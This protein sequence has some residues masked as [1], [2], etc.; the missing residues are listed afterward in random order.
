MTTPK[1]PAVRL[2]GVNGG[3]C[4][5]RDG[6]VLELP[7]SSKFS[8]SWPS[9]TR[10]A[11]TPPASERSNLSFSEGESE[12]SD[13]DS[14]N[15]HRNSPEHSNDA[16]VAATPMSART[17]AGPRSSP[18]LPRFSRALSMPLPSQLGYL[19]HPHRSGPQ[20][21]SLS[22]PATPDSEPLK[23]LSVEL[24][25]SVQMVIQTMLQ[26][27]PPQLLDP[28]KEQFSACALSVPI[29]SMSAILTS[30]K[31]LN[32]ISAN[33]PGLCSYPQ[34]PEG[35]RSTETSRACTPA[36]LIDFDIGEMLQSVGD[37]LSGAAAQAGVDLVLYHGDDIGL[38][39]VCVRGDEGGISYA[40]SHVRRKSTL[41][42]R[43][44]PDIFC[45]W[46]VRCWQ[47]LSRVTR[48][49]WDCSWD[50]WIRTLAL[51]Y[52]HQMTT[53]HQQNQRESRSLARYA[54][55]TNSEQQQPSAI[56]PLQLDLSPL[57]ILFSYSSFSVK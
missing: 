51:R 36:I 39:H 54:Y 16:K 11:S 30:M 2:R 9:E 27:T 7:L 1:L 47:R 49:S 57:F 34:S 19:K 21:G 35:S 33:M 20:E 15:E 13:S 43:T 17:N 42:S 37:S 26:I 23:E 29:S 40:L 50:L 6:V 12:P 28:A 25:D 46:C 22:Y 8:V 45:R 10:T 4:V 18:T 3:E 56:C 48:S 53:P 38:R 41:P 24:A 52:L 14:G 44:H 5:T 31:N 55:P 32:Y